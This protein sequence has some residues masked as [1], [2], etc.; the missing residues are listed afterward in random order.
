M[1][2]GR[3]WGATE[4]TCLLGCEG[5]LQ[6]AA[7]SKEELLPQRGLQPLLLLHPGL[8]DLI[9]FLPQGL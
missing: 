6:V 9:T 8:E 4:G 7:L 2:G 1:F 5:L 3:R